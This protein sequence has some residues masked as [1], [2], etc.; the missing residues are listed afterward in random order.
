MA[1]FIAMN[2]EV[3]RKLASV[4]RD[5]AKELRATLDRIDAIEADIKL[6]HDSSDD[7]DE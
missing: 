3:I 6:A 2:K 1:K 7:V 4:K 5:K